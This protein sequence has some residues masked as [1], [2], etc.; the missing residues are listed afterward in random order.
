MTKRRRSAKETANL[1]HASDLRL[2][3][4]TSIGL[5]LPGLVF[6][7]KPSL[8]LAAEHPGAMALLYTSALFALSIHLG[9]QDSPA[10]G[11]LAPLVC[12]PLALAP[13]LLAA[14]VSTLPMPIGLL[15]LLPAVVYARAAHHAWRHLRPG[16]VTVG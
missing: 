13:F 3:L 8:F 16:A 4:E 7:L 14:P 5:L 11:R 15:A 1:T 9:L 6:I 12:G 2:L 10:Y